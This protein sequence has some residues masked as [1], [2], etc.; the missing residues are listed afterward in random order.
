MRASSAGVGAGGVQF[1]VSVVRGDHAIDAP[2]VEFREDGLGDRA[3]GRRL[4][5]GTELVDE[6]EGLFVR[7]G[8][9]VPHVGEEGT[10]GAEVVFQVL[11]VP[12]AHRDPVEDGKFR[13]FGCGDEHA[14]LEHVLQQARRLEADGLAA[15]VRP[16]NEQDALAFREGDGQRDDAA[17]LPRE[18]LF[19]QRVARLAQG[20]AAVFGDDRHPGDHVEGGLR[21]RHQEVDLPDEG[22]P[23]EQVGQVGTEEFGE[24]EQDLLDLAA[25]LEAEFGDVV[26][27]FDD[28]GRLHE[29]GLAGG[30][31]VVHEALDLALGGGP[32]GNE[33]LAVA[34]GHVGVGVHDALLLRLAEDG[35]GALGDRGFLAAQVAPDLEEAVGGGVLDVAVLVEDALDAALDLRETPD[36]GGEPLQAGVDAALDA[37]E[38]VEDAPEG[39]GDGLELAQA[40]HVDAGSRALQGAQEGDGVDVA[41]GGEVLLEHQDQAHLVGEGEPLPDD[42]RI[43][44]EALFCHAAGGVIR[45]A[46][47]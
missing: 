33:E 9:Q 43:R 6:H 26:L 12:D 5:A 3:A 16:G 14:P 39:V 41:G 7:V 44:A 35:P 24:L 13:A 40:Q 17:S 22:G 11:V 19:Q 15:R 32:H 18:R 45:H 31:D 27:Q 37:A 36:R 1:Q 42:G 8:E 30:G 4:R 21:L 23:G 38:E 25:L 34:D 47:V 29:G 20:Q 2:A 10:V 46:A 28:L